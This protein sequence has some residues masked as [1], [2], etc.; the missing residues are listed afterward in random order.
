MTIAPQN[1]LAIRN[2]VAIMLLGLI[3]GALAHRA[4]GRMPDDGLGVIQCVRPVPGP[5]CG[6]GVPAP[7]GQIPCGN[8]NFHEFEVVP[9]Q[10]YIGCE[11]SSIGYKYC[12]PG[13]VA[14]TLRRYECN[15]KNPLA[16]VIVSEVPYGTACPSFSFSR[17]ICGAVNPA[18]D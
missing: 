14:P 2:P 5:V 12:D 9:V 17:V 1:V 18:G 6:L 10:T 7:Q 13:F 16:P 8:P 4:P 11:S 15:P 3:T